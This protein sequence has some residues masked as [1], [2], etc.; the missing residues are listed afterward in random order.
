MPW[1]MMFLLVLSWKGCKEKDEIKF[2]TTH[3]LFPL[4]QRLLPHGLRG[5]EHEEQA[6]GNLGHLCFHLR[7]QSQGESK[8]R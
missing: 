4:Q 7:K 6:M 8:A 5:E 1:S 3:E 2:P